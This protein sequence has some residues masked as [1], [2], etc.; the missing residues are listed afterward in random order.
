MILILIFTFQISIIILHQVGLIFL[1][2]RIKY[3][4]MEVLEQPKRRKSALNVMAIC[5]QRHTNVSKQIAIL[6]DV[7]VDPPMTRPR[8][9][10]W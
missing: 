7:D 10:D 5:D 8:S 6:A 9:H 2:F 4:I 1:M 3:C